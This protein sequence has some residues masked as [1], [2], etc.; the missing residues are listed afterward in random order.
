MVLKFFCDVGF[1]LP[2]DRFFCACE[3]FF[4]GAGEFLRAEKL[5]GELNNFTVTLMDFYSVSEKFGG[6]ETNFLVLEGY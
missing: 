5:C 3:Q 2:A 6:A 1:I 4:Q